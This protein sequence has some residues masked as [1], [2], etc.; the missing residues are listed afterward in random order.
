MDILTSPYIL[1]FIVLIVLA[2]I[3]W[4]VS[5]YG[6]R[7]AK[8]GTILH[9]KK[10]A[11][12]VGA[13]HTCSTFLDYDKANGEYRNRSFELRLYEHRGAW[14]LLNIWL[15]QSDY[16]LRIA[17]KSIRESL[18]R[19]RKS[20]ILNGCLPVFL[21]SI[22]DLKTS[23]SKKTQRLLDNDMQALVM[24]LFEEF[25]ITRLEGGMG[26]IR[27]LISDPE[28]TEELYFKSI[29]DTTIEFADRIEKQT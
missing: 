10:F 24:R 2:A 27:V 7:R 21:E 16:Y 12:Q 9:L 23:D 6:S 8:S 25:K 29:L 22:L 13:V 1:A 11:E 14:L 17:R 19:G 15:K 3:L 26:E 4:A 18:V 28:I 20:E 5:C